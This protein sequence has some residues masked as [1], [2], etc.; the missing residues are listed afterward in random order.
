MNDKTINVGLIG[1]G[2]WASEAH[3][4]ALAAHPHASTIAIQTRSADKARK[5]TERFGIPQAFTT[6]E[7]LLALPEL[8]AV[9]IS[10]TPNVHFAQAR[11]ALDRELHVLI[12]KP[13]TLR[14]SESEEL[15]ALAD[16]KGV[17]F[18]ISCPW[19]YSRHGQLARERIASGALGTIRLVNIFMSN[20]TLG[21]L[22]GK[23]FAEA[24]GGSDGTDASI[25]P[26][27]EPNRNSYSDP[28][29][30]G[31]GHIYTQASHI[32]AYIGF[33]TGL[34]P[35]EISA[36]FDSAGTAVDAT[37]AMHI[38][39]EGGALGA[40]GTI[41]T[42]SDVE[43]YFEVRVIGTKGVLSLELWKGH[44]H[45]RLSD[46]SVEDPLPLAEDEIYPKFGPAWNLVDAA[47][48]TSC[49]RSPATLGHYAMRL[50]EGACHSA[51]SGRPVK[52]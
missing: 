3:L 51:A 52:F 38:R 35:V 25:T 45:L 47:R 11:A 39:F 48:G 18:L 30:A 37:N 50:I 42:H 46:G 49:N 41:S 40:V 9:I 44:F 4:P 1:A 34:D 26:E 23:S 31:G 10:S 12:E 2:W 6:A 16:R 7:D 24:L 13:M 15:V 28:D 21:F 17:Q 33:L 19:H 5:L 22:E 43:R 29:T 14:A 20:F 32:F 36:R 27:I 8:D